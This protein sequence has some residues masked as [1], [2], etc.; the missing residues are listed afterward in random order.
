MFGNKENLHH[1]YLI[2][3]DRESIFSLVSDYLEKELKFSLKNNPDFWNGDFETFGIDDGRKINE[4]Q[5]KK[6][7]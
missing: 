2:E 3:G 5:N 6:A 1:A 7:F 4:L